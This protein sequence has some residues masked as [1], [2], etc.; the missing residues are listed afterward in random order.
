MPTVRLPSTDACGVPDSSGFVPTL[1][2][3]RRALRRANDGVILDATEAE[4]LLHARG[5]DL[6]WLLAASTRVRDAHCY[7]STIDYLRA[8]AIRVLEETGLL[9]HLNP[10]VMTWQEIQRL[11]PVAP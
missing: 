2:A 10:G 7:F 6:D 4:T 3:L 1:S 8:I 9:P 11:K 5:D